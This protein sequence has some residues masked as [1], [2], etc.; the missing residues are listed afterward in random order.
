MLCYVSTFLHWDPNPAPIDTEAFRRMALF[1]RW[2]EWQQGC[3][4]VYLVFRDDTYMAHNCAHN[5]NETTHDPIFICV[6]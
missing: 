4:S 3:L 5:T 2:F 6:E 1:L